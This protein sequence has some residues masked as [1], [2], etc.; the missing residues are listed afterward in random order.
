M[1]SLTAFLPNIPNFGL[2]VP[3]LYERQR[4]LVRLGH[5]PAPK[6]R[7]RGSGVDATPRSVAMLIIAIMATD[8]L[9]DTDA[10]VKRLA[11]AKVDAAIYRHGCGVTGA[12]TFVEALAA[13]LGSE[14]LCRLVESAIVSRSNLSARIFYRKP[15]KRNY[16]EAT[17][18]G[19]D[20]PREFDVTSHVSGDMLRFVCRALKEQ[21][22]AAK[23]GSS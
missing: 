3:A 19:P 1:V 13:L 9:S 20:Y 2:S 18:F 4:A 16:S 5:L 8:N 15:P 12:T 17:V 22:A 11:N 23:G 14:D 7:G 6:G 21:S 10:R